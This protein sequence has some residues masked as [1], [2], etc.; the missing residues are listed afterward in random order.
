[1]R[2]SLVHGQG[3]HRAHCNHAGLSGAASWGVCHPFCAG[4]LSHEH[5]SHKPTGPAQAWDTDGILGT[6]WCLV[7][8]LVTVSKILQQ[9]VRI[10]GSP[11]LH[12]DN[13]GNVQDHLRKVMAWLSIS[14]VLQTPL[15]WASRSSVSS[16]WFHF[17]PLLIRHLFV[18]LLSSACADQLWKQQEFCC[19]SPPAQS[20][21]PHCHHPD[22]SS[23]ADFK[24]N[25]R[26]A[27]MDT[28]EDLAETWTFQFLPY[29]AGQFA[30]GTGYCPTVS[31]PNPLLLPNQPFPQL[32]PLSQPLMVKCSPFP[33]GEC[34]SVCWKEAPL[35]PYKTQTHYPIIAHAAETK[36]Q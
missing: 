16:V 9:S 24:G 15:C 18:S 1:M 35:T 31:L 27:E 6:Q 19:A 26:Q 10:H 20:W 5:P 25:A 29:S 34:M 30:K 23:P 17:L 32:L 12:R 21:V 13:A 7:S 14:Q 36:G 4:W 2:S 8:G 33:L 3:W 22:P 28:A 11:W